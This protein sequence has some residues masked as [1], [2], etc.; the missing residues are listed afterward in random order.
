[1]WQAEATLSEKAEGYGSTQ[2]LLFLI[3]LSICVLLSCRAP[4]PIHFYLPLLMMP[5]L[6]WMIENSVRRVILKHKLDETK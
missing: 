5:K 6:K 1:M 4:S 3:I 2:K